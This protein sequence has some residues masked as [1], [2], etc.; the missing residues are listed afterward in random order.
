MEI[1]GYFTFKCAIKRFLSFGVYYAA[2][3]SGAENMCNFIFKCGIKKCLNF[4][5]YYVAC[6]YCV[7]NK[8]NFTLETATSYCVEYMDNFTIKERCKVPAP[9]RKQHE[10]F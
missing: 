9:G 2:C 6:S 10:V 5:V 3:S 1:M 8:D 4:G 7:E